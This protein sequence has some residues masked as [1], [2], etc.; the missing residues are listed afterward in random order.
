MNTFTK[1]V[2]TFLAAS[3]IATVALAAPGD[4]TYGQSTRGQLNSLE[5]QAHDVNVSLEGNAAFA[6]TQKAS[7]ENSHRAEF[8]Q[9]KLN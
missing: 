6:L 1:S 4:A 9:N 5:S 8:L 3:S 7:A 2:A